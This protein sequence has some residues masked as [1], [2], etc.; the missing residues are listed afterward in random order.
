M[1]SFSLLLIRHDVDRLSTAGS[2]PEKKGQKMKKVLRGRNVPHSWVG[3]ETFS[4][5]DGRLWERNET[6]KVAC[7]TN[8]G[9]LHEIT[10]I[11]LH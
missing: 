2:V 5:V 3:G 4:V 1:I 11:S 6:Q 10:P 9:H 8:R 7:E